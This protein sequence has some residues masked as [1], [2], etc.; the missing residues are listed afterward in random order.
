MMSLAATYQAVQ[1]SSVMM[2]LVSHHLLSV[3]QTW[4]VLM[5]PM[6]Q[7]A[8]ILR[9]LPFSQISNVQNMMFSKIMK[10][11]CLNL[12]ASIIFC[13]RECPFKMKP[14]FPSDTKWFRGNAEV[15]E[16]YRGGVLNIG[17]FNTC[18][19]QDIHESHRLAFNTI[20]VTR[21]PQTKIHLR[22]VTSFVECI[23]N[24]ALASLEICHVYFGDGSKAGRLVAEKTLI[25]DTFDIRNSPLLDAHFEKDL[26]TLPTVLS[27]K[28]Y[29]DFVAKYGT[30]YT[31]HTVRGGQ[32]ILVSNPLS[33]TEVDRTEMQ[34]F[35]QSPSTERL[36][37]LSHSYTGF[38]VFTKGG[39][40]AITPGTLYDLGGSNTLVADMLDWEHSLPLQSAVLKLDSQQ[41]PL[42]E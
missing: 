15:G 14:T 9:M 21:S 41:T 40:T 38:T 32:L 16:K 23:G 35:L 2:A 31:S 30:H 17:F 6:R 37:K 18:V 10:K 4:T 26:Q 36:E 29:G 27:Y 42:Y 1:T 7:A 8:K 3:I 39:S 28:L 20:H 25:T 22:M 5:A 24:R 11:L 19:E 12:V 13:S 33:G 34:D